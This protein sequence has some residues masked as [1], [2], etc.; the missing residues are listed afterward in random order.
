MFR[1]IFLGFNVDSSIFSIV[2]SKH[3]NKKMHTLQQ[4]HQIHI[5]FDHL[6]ILEDIFVYAPIAKK[7]NPHAPEVFSYLV[8]SKAVCNLGIFEQE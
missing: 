3:D 7:D 6:K 4:I 5:I 2:E 8:C 1:F